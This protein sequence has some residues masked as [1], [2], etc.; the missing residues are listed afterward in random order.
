L[1]HAHRLLESD[2]DYRST[3]EID[4][5]VK[6]IAPAGMKLVP[7]KRGAHSR[8]HKHNLQADEET[9]LAEPVDLYVMK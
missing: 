7:I 1:I 8:E 3:F 5:K 2:R 9:P 6:G 4:A